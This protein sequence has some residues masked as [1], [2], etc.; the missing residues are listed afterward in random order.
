[1]LLHRVHLNHL[2]GG[3]WSDRSL[4]TWL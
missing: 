1:V 2:L 3:L 4:L